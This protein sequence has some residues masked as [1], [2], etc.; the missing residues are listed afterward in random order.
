MNWT[1]TKWLTVI[2]WYYFLLAR[3][4][5]FHNKHFIFIK[6]HFFTVH[7]LDGAPPHTAK[8]SR[9]W[10][11]ANFGDRVISFKTDFVWAPYSP[12]LNPLDF[13]LWGHLKDIV[14]RECPQ[15]VQE[16]KDLI[17]DSIQ[18]IDQDKA[19]CRRVIGHFQRRL[20]VCVERGGRHLEHVL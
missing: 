12:D 17:V 8:E 16:L 7:V 9:Q 3:T 19:L 20:N 5:V 10:L 18:M 14:Y 2:S 1:L 4:I 11:A 6:K 13:F 15:T